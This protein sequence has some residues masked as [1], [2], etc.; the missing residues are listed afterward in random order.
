MAKV[1]TEQRE[2]N[3]K[4]KTQTNKKKQYGWFKTNRIETSLAVPWL[5]LHAST[6]GGPGSIPGRRA[7]I[8]QAAA[9]PKKKMQ[10]WSD[11]I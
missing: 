5:G 1:Q 10:T 3:I 8:P 7:K 6:S 2:K 11:C 9:W 4:S